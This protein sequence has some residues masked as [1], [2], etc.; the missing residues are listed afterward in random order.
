[1]S[2]S[3]KPLAARPARRAAAR[4][5]ATLLAIAAA[6]ASGTASG[7]ATV[8]ESRPVAGFTR[9][10]MDAPGELTIRQGRHEALQI[11]AEPRLLPKIASEVRN[12]VLYLDIRAEIFQT[13]HPL[14]FDLTVERLDTLTVTSSADV[15][16][17][18]LRTK[19]LR[20][21]LDGSGNI[22]I[23]GLDAARLETQLTGSADFTVG[24]GRV[25]QQILHA[26]G[27]GDYA[28]GEMQSAT[29]RIELAGSGN[30]TVRASQQ[31][32]VLSTGSGDL[33]YLGNPRI[34]QR[35]EG[36]GDVLRVSSW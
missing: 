8:R 11:E 21:E 5:L 7:A 3:S 34:E 25:A 19:R 17:G 35:V 12:G 4:T 33:H 36:S 1:M 13:S 29:A 2:S 20:L 23:E 24:G 26:T 28:S 14:R 10:V 22:V 30:A 27:S 9:V 6:G 16:T 15:R 32:D 31:I 18:P